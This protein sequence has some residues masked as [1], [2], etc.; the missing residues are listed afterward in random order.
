MG[1]ASNVPVEPGNDLPP[2]GVVY[3]RGFARQPP[4]PRQGTLVNKQSEERPRSAITRAGGFVESGVQIPRITQQ[5]RLPAF[6]Y[7]AH[8]PYAWPR[9]R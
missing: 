1:D 3:V 5:V 2:P 4:D 8:D 7:S 9:S 6:K